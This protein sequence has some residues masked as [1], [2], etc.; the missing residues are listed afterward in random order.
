M[1]IEKVKELAEIFHDKRVAFERLGVM[2]ISSNPD[3]HRKQTVELEV[4]RAE[5]VEAKENLQT[6]QG[7]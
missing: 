2:G 1:D 5:M 7:L 4:A 3:E 6:E